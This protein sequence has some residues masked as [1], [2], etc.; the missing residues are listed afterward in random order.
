M[1]IIL[2]GHGNYLMI[3]LADKPLVKIGK[4]QFTY[5]DFGDY[6][7]DAQSRAGSKTDFKVLVSKNYESFINSNLVEY[8][9]DN[10]EDENTEFADVVSE[11]RDGLLLFDLMETTIWNTAKSD[12]L[13]IENFYNTHK[14]KYVYPKR[15]D[16]IVASSKDE[17]TLKKVA[18]LLEEGMALDQIKGLIN[19][20]NKID[21]MF[22]SDV[23]DETHQALPKGF[24]FKNG[25]SKIYK[26]NDASVLVLVKEVFPET[27]K[28]FEECKRSCNKRLSA[29]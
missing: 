6:L 18:K 15:V 17:R 3:L 27:Q 29:F 7:V 4:K 2:K 13:E 21:V 1:M 19:S 5:K 11:Y 14:A 26:H 24:E 16:A 8:Q 12:S 20:N 23:M 28:T 10:L 22:T 9:E 25:I